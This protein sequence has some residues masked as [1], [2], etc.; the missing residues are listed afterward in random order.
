[1]WV[2]ARGGREEREEQKARERERERRA[3]KQCKKS[4]VVKGG[5]MAWR[6]G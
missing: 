4:M 3:G 6:E 1:M 2:V 5:R